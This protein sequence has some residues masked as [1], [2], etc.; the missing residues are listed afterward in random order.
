MSCGPPNRRSATS[1]ISSSGP[2]SIGADCL[3]E[4]LLGDAAEAVAL[5]PH[6]AGHQ[7]FRGALHHL[8]HGK[9]AGRRIAREQH[10]GIFGIDHALDQHVAG[11]GREAVARHA[12]GLERRLDAGDRRF[13][14]VAIDVDHQLE[15]AGEAVV[16]AVLAAP[17]LRTAS[18][19]V[20]EPLPD[21]AELVVAR[22]GGRGGHP[23][24]E[25][26]RQHDA[27]RH[28]HSGRAHLREAIGLVA[29]VLAAAT[30]PRAR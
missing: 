11:A 5:R 7:I 22:R 28:R 1:P 4:R 30:H 9:A 2:R 13:Q 21:P 15:H 18:L 8:D 6:R 14:S 26:G 29:A 25:G 17:E 16:C 27:I 12:R 3:A 24:Q 23:R 19:S 10:A 20:A